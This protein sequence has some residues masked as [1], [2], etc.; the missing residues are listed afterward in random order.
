MKFS[1]PLAALSLCAMLARGETPAELALKPY[2]PPPAPDVKAWPRERLLGF[3]HELADFVE[4]NHLVTDPAHKTYGMVYEFWKDGKKMQEFGLDSMH[5]GAWFM[6]ALVVAQ[7]ADPKGDWLARA[8]KYEIPF[9]TNLLNHSDQLFPKMQPTEEDKHPWSAPLKGWAPRGWDDGTGF[10]RKNGQPMPDGYFTGSNHL[11]QD[12]ADALLNVW[13]STR[14]PQV[15]EAVTHLRDY[16]QEYFG[17]ISGIDVAAAVSAGQADAFL[18]YKAPDLSPRACLLSYAGL[19][20]KKAV[21]LPV[22]DDGLAWLYRQGT[23]GALISGEFPHGFATCAIARS[24]GA[25]VGMETFFDDRP[26]PYGAWFFDLQRAPATL[27]GKGKLADYSSTAKNFYG[28]RGAQIAWIAAALLPELKAQP[29]L[30]DN[31][32]KPGAGEAIVRLVDE[33][34]TTDGVKDA[35]YAKSAPLGDDAARVTLISDPRN[36]HV[37]IETTRPQLT[38]TFQEETGERHASRI[39]EKTGAKIAIRESDARDLSRP[40]AK[41]K[42]THKKDDDDDK[43][44]TPPPEP[45]FTRGGKLTVTKEGLCT[46]VNE[47]GEALLNVAA[48]KP[49]AFKQGNGDG[50]IAEVRIPYTFVP[51][52]NAWI[53]GVDFGRYRVGID[54]A[55]QQTVCLRSEAARVQKRLENGVLGTIDFWNKVW[56]E[57]GIIPSG[58]HT[59][60]VSAG[61]W[62]LSDAGG[63]AHLMH[64]MAFW[65]IYQDGHREWEIIR[66][67]FPKTPTPAPPLPESVLKA[68]GLK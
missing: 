26:Y 11:A 25:I 47:K 58:W 20:E 38:V 60:S 9:Y 6:S 66:E 43:K 57:R 63:Y 35:V 53:N 40:T 68:Q 59:P 1:L 41:K 17:P 15:A 24:Y 44:D 12:L 62:E 65:L 14:D 16:K 4:K 30:W 51:A 64:A 48:F 23:A 10:Q 55:P 52:Q 39:V 46:L 13:L 56:K 36:L 34:P 7:R 19:F 61:G 2:V 21:Q 29:A 33:P 27:D 8:Q 50:W 32:A 37:F 42:P 31:M 54:T 5:D 3:M 22:Y 49:D 67:Q 45:A 18:K 28:S